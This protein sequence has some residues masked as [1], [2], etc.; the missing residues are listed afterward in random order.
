MRLSW[1]LLVTAC[2]FE[3]GKAVED[4]PKAP[5]DMAA[6][7]AGNGSQIDGSTVDPAPCVTTGLA[8]AGSVVA[9][10]CNGA[11]WIACT[12]S[13]AIPSQNAAAN[14]CAAWGG[15][16]APLRTLADHQCVVSTLFPNYAH[17]IGLEQSNNATSVAA[18]WTWNGDGIAITFEAWGAGQPDDQNANENGTEQCAF[19]GTTGDWHDEQCGSNGLYRFSCRR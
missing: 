19:I 14:A 6:D 10:P 17:W 2:G 15:K 4:A 9:M 5:G 18:G 11:C 1:L 12:S 8:C 3:P 7:A 16:L 13:V